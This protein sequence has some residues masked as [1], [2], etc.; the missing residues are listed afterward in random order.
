[1]S[2]EACFRFEEIRNDRVIPGKVSLRFENSVNNNKFSRV[3]NDGIVGESRKYPN[4]IPIGIRFRKFSTGS[5]SRLR[6][7]GAVREGKKRIEIRSYDVK[8]QYEKRHDYSYVPTS[9]LPF[10]PSPLVE[11]TRSR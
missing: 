8:R 6:G 2:F 3:K 10:S 4:R 9:L 5:N 7:K 11:G 1:M